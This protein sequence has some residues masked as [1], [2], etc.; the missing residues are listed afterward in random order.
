[1]SEFSLYYLYAYQVIK[2]KL[3]FYKE[4]LT[5]SSLFIDNYVVY[6]AKYLSLGSEAWDDSIALNED[7]WK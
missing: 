2:V 7:N 6:W 3:Y 5:L 4:A 1:M